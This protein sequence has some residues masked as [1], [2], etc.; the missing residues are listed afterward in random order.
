MAVSPVLSKLMIYFP[1]G[2]ELRAVIRKLTL[3]LPTTA[4]RVYYL[5]SALMNLKLVELA[6]ELL[7]A[8]INE[9]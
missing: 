2:D 9:A 1:F 3:G 7:A 4:L 5:G 8:I 6:V